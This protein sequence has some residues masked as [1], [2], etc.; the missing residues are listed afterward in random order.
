M[1]QMID[2]S[3]EFPD[4]HS[5]GNPSQL[6]E[7]AILAAVSESRAVLAANA[8]ISVVLCGDAFIRELNR[9][10]RGRDE[11]TNV[12]S[13][14]AAGDLAS[15]PLLGDIIIAFETTAREAAEAG[16]PLRDH[17][18]HLVV[19]GFLH[20]IGHDHAE[21]A[22]AVAME[23]LERAILAKLGI[24]DPYGAALIEEAAAAHE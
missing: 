12:L 1:S 16:K 4:W 13:F 23:T 22:E 10:W 2:I 9:K 20:L 6:V 17:L 24:A 7:D 8:E 5:L 11:P 19:H 3:I 14:P 15:A 18:A 21:T